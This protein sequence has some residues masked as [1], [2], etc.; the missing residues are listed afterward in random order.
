MPKADLNTKLVRWP[1]AYRLKNKANTMVSIT[2]STSTWADAWC[3]KGGQK[4]CTAWNPAGMAFTER[5]LDFITVSNFHHSWQNVINP[6]L[7]KCVYLPG[8]LLGSPTWHPCAQ[9]ASISHYS[10]KQPHLWQG[11]APCSRTKPSWL[12]LHS[13][14]LASCL[15]NACS[16]YLSKSY[17]SQGSS[18]N[19]CL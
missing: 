8:T 2:M 17:R 16:P 10:A 19:F 13:C 14:R 1:P 12:I 15:W 11:Q 3:Q 7:A 18:P 5:H 4:H 6:P 9:R